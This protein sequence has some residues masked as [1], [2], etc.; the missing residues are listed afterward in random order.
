M[1]CYNNVMLTQLMI[2][3]QFKTINRYIKH[4]LKRS[5]KQ[6]RSTW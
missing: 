1:S 4:L 3:L 2:L 5:L 6:I